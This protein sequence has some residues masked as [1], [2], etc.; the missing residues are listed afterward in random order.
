[1]L[2]TLVERILG[3]F[4]KKVVLGGVRGGTTGL[5]CSVSWKPGNNPAALMI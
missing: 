2:T 5:S 4:K 3:K 1:M